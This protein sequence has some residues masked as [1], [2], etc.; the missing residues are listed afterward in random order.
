M[1]FALCIVKTTIPLLLLLAISDD[2][3]PTYCGALL[4]ELRR[5]KMEV[6]QIL[7]FS[8]PM[9]SGLGH[10]LKRELVLHNDA[11]E[12]LSV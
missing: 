11:D 7:K 9:R 8:G 1:D 2:A 6:D 3:R 12:I 5:C 4:R 10:W